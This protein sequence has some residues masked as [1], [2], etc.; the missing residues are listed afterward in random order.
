MVGDGMRIAP[1]PLQCAGLGQTLRSSQIEE[2]IDGAERKP[3]RHGGVASMAHAM[4]Q[5]HRLLGKERFVDALSERVGGIELGQG[6][7]D[8]SLHRALS[9]TFSPK[10]ETL[11]RV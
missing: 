10:V 6:F 3:R 9:A 11:V 4:L 2:T 5:C 7:A 8:R 1:M